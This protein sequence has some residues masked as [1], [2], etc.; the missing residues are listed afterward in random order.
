MLEPLP[1]GADAFGSKKFGLKPER[2]PLVR[3]GWM[4][5]KRSRSLVGSFLSISDVFIRSRCFECLESKLDL[6]GSGGLFRYR[7][8]VV[9]LR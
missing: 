2:K 6:D 9:V 7:I 8:D 3:S 4:P 1:D 5:L